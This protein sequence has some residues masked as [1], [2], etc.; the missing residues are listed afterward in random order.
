MVRE[1]GL[2][3]LICITVLCIFAIG[4][5]RAAEGG[6][7]SKE[8]RRDEYKAAMAR[9]DTDYK[10]AKDACVTKPRHER[11]EC[12]RDARADHAKATHEAKELLR[13]KTAMGDHEEHFDARYRAAREKCE[14]LSDDARDSCFREARERFHQ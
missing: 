9:A 13:A 3:E 11:A 14:A 2:P 10:T 7:E 8:Q 5:A 12:M 4:T 6:M 1:L